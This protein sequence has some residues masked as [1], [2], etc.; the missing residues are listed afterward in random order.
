[1][2]RFLLL[3]C[4]AIL[5]GYQSMAQ[6]PPPQT[7]TEQPDTS[8][9]RFRILNADRQGY[10]R[11]DS[12]TELQFLAGNVHL[13]QG[14]TLLDCDSAVFNTSKRII[15]AFGNIHINDEDSVHTYSQYLLYY[16]DT[17]IAILKK[18]VRLT[19]GKTNL[20]SEELQY[21]VNQ[22]IGEYHNGGRL[23][24]STSTLT[25]KEAV[26]YADLKDVYF[27]RDV[28]LKDPKYKLKTDSLIYNTDTE[29]ATFIAQTYIEDSAK[30]KIRTREGFYD[31]KN[32]RAILT[33]RSTIEDGAV[34][35]IGDKMTTNDSTGESVLEGNAV[36][37]DTAQGVAILAGKIIANNKESTFEATKQPLMIIRQENDS[38]YV[39]ADTLFSGRLSKLVIPRDSLSMTDTIKGTVVI[40]AKEIRNDSADRFIRA[41]SHVKIFSD[42][43]QGVCDSLFYSGRDSVFQMFKDP[44][45]WANNSQVTGD[46]IYLYTKN[47]KADRLY[48]FDNGLMIN[49]AR[50]DMFNQIRGNRL[51]GYFKEGVIDYMR[52]RGNAE[53]VYYIEDDDSAIVGVNRASGDIIDMRFAESELNRVV[54]INEVKGTMYPIRQLP[55]SEKQ[56][57]NFKWREAQR[58][59]NKYELFAD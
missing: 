37:K 47:K 2:F 23:V 29:I 17:K 43:L 11:V 8:A 39:K 45:L 14:T 5:C 36:Y 7:T 59:K 56:L 35:A 21:D 13:Q 51:D 34:T 18:K 55:E 1:M 9:K 27:K 44:V 49:K 53:S 54:F 10:R 26:Y 41:H 19:D 50:A 30:R 57:R 4:I 15:E 32:K 16:V 20:Y 31:L 24:N 3:C 25:S 22:K 46:T 42:S 12:L 28:D 6:F 58:P 48:V 33:S 52:A 40:D 38:I